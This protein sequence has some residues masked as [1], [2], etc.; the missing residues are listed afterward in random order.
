ML[1]VIKVDAKTDTV[2]VGEEKYLFQKEAR[3]HK[4]HLLSPIGENER[5]KVKIRY[6][7]GGA[8]A[9]VKMSQGNKAIVEFEEPQRAVTPGQA[10]VIYRENRLMGGGW[11][12]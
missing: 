2:W 6:Q 7:H 9:Q 8:W 11:I 1:F 10:A 5:V 3:V 12:E 4:L